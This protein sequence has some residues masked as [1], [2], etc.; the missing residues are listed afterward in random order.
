MKKENEGVANDNLNFDDLLAF[1]KEW[2]P[3]SFSALK[4]NG[5]WYCWGIDE[6]LMDI[7]AEIL[8]PMQKENKITF[9]NLLTWD[10]KNGQGQL[11]SEFRM[12]PIADE[13]SLTRPA[14]SFDPSISLSPDVTFISIYCTP[15]R[16]NGPI[17]NAT[18]VSK[19]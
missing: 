2:I 19:P 18:T 3:L 7:Y 14:V 4:E 12:Y 1:N 8:K 5:S 10:K 9:R 13:K 11:A 16:I 6:P 17:H 15:M